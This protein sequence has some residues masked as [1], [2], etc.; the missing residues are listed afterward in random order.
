MRKKGTTFSGTERNRGH[1]VSGP[2]ARGGGKKKRRERGVMAIG[3]SSYRGGGDRRERG[4]G[5]AFVAEKRVGILLSFMEKGKGGKIL[6]G[7]GKGKERKRPYL[8]KH[9]GK[10]RKRVSFWAKKKELKEASFF[11]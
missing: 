7:G 4:G 11:T 9:K 10:K 5:L 1:R 6:V 8:S 3:P 2:Q